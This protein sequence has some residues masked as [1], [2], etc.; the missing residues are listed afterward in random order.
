MTPSIE[1]YGVVGGDSLAPTVIVRT[2][3]VSHE[4]ER[5]RRQDV[6][7][8]S[9]TAV[10]TLLSGK[11]FELDTLATLRFGLTRILLRRVR[12]TAYVQ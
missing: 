2:N 8:I 6:T 9:S 12:R 11:T 7:P 4:D 10:F 3:A 1:T 5:I